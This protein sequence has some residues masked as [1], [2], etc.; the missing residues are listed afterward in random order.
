MLDFLAY[1]DGTNDLIDISNYI[2]ISVN[3]LHEVVEKL[4]QKDVISVVTKT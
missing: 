3:E 2:H 4:L 1:C